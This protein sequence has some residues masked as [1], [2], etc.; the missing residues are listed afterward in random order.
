MPNPNSRDDERNQRRM[1]GKGQ[2]QASRIG[3][4]RTQLFLSQTRQREC[5]SDS[6]W[7]YGACIALR[8]RPG[9]KPIAK[10]AHPV[11]RG[12]VGVVPHP[13]AE[14]RGVR[15]DQSLTSFD[16]ARKLS[17]FCVL[18]KF[19]FQL[20]PKAGG[21][22]VYIRTRYLDLWKKDEAG[23]WK[24]AVFMDNADVPDTVDAAAA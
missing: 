9:L 6:G 24:L 12:I 19:G 13:Q 3:G 16:L 11:Q 23:Q 14:L 4:Q 20:A 10:F 15:P 1:G 8:P 7:P 18:E 21:G 17:R 5:P 2:Q 22:P